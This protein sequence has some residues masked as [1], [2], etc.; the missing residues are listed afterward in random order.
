M[1]FQM[2]N[3]AA[4]PGKAWD[5]ASSRGWETR[6]VAVAIAQEEVMT[7]T[8]RDLVVMMGTQRRGQQDSFCQGE[9]AELGGLRDVRAGMGRDLS[10]QPQ[11]LEESSYRGRW[12][13][14]RGRLQ[15]I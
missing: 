3:L 5:G 10:S 14:R 7:A 13:W 12:L 6:S 2:I 1:I 8:I 4:E 15:R 9:S 11:S